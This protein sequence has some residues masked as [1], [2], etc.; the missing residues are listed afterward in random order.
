MDDI[1]SILTKVKEDIAA[2][3]GLRCIDDINMAIKLCEKKMNFDGGARLAGLEELIPLEGMSEPGAEVT[4]NA[5][6]CHIYF[7]KNIYASDLTETKSNPP[8]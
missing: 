4:I 1:I 2:G 7:Y 6:E 8:T 5:N 3:K